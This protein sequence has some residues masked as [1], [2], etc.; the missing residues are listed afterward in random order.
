MGDIKKDQE[1]LVRVH[2]ECLTGDLLGSY[3]CDCGSQLHEALEMIKSEGNGVLL[4]LRQE[5]RGIGL[6]HKIKAYSLQE[7]GLDTVEANEALGYKAD[8]REYG[9]GAQILRDLGL[10]KIKLL[11]NNPTKVV[12]LEGFGLKITTI[13]PIEI[14]PGKY[15]QKYLQTKKRKLRHKLTDV[16]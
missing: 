7:E 10:N 9:T 13:V 4:Y 14:E 16:D 3:R 1:T 2:S 15:N 6:Q 12:G 8:L 5:G 11:T